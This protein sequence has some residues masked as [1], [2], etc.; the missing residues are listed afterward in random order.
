MR[1]LRAVREGRCYVLD[2]NA[3]FN[4]PGPRL[5]DSAELLAAVLH[6][7]IFPEERARYE[8]AWAPWR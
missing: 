5:A 4:R 3:Y 1:R 6:P 2:G 8:G 7:E